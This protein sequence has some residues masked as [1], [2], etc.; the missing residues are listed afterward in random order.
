MTRLVLKRI[1]AEQ[2]QVRASSYGH[3]CVSATRSS[4]PW[5]SGATTMYV[6]PN[7]C[8]PAASVA[9]AGSRGHLVPWQQCRSGF[10]TWAA[11]PTQ[12]GIIIPVASHMFRPCCMRRAMMT[13][14]Y[15]RRKHARCQ[16]AWCTRSAARPLRRSSPRLR[17]SGSSRPHP[18][19]R[20]T[21]VLRE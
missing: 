16:V 21:Y 9:Y 1:S 19:C 8:K 18:A 3:L 12:A 4:S 17:G 10:D 5:Y 13:L 2:L 6:T 7:I 11:R 20:S 14:V 15:M